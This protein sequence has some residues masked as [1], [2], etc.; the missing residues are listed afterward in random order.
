MLVT[1]LL[2]SCKN[3]TTNNPKN[4]TSFSLKKKKIGAKKGKLAQ[5]I[6][7]KLKKIRFAMGNHSLP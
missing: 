2:I 4:R 1:V 6:D 3:Q 7:L 5:I